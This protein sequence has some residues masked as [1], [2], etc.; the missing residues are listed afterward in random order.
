MEERIQIHW[1]AELNAIFFKLY[2]SDIEK[3]KEDLRVMVGYVFFH[4]SVLFA[5]NEF[6][7]IGEIIKRGLLPSGM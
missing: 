6:S 2:R 7:E 3:K 4:S 1:F 5:I